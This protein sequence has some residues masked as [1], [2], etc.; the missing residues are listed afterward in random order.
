MQ[1]LLAEIPLLETS[2]HLILQISNQ[3]DA[4]SDGI[5]SSLE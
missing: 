3:F 5:Y 4:D 2:Y 1:F